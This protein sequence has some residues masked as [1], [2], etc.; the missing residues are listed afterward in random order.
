VIGALERGI[1]ILE[2]LGERGE[3]RLADVAKELETSRAT[4]F[5]TLATLQS[6]GYVEHVRAARVYRL[7]HAL[8][9]LAAGATSSAVPRV[10]APAMAELRAVTTET[11]NLGVVR[12]GRIVYVAILDG[13]HALRVNSEVGEE[14]PPHATAIGKSILSVLPLEQ[15]AIFLRPEPYPS[16][17]ERTITTRAALDDELRATAKRGYGIDDQETGVG[18][19]CIAAPIVGVDGYPIAAISVSAIAARLPRKKFAA[20]GRAVKRQAEWVSNEIATLEAD[21]RA[22][23]Q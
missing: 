1:D 5:R 14:V 9:T 20:L 13:V 21:G 7:G 8:Q 18:A 11:V 10:A 6:R 2:L 3:M 19:V 16:F 15:R 23:T 17:T 12:R 4:A 22:A